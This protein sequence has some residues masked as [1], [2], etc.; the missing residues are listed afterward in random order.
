MESLIRNVRTPGWYPPA[1]ASTEAALLFNDVLRFDVNNAELAAA[2]NDRLRPAGVH[3][4]FTS[5]GVQLDKHKRR[6]TIAA[7]FVFCKDATRVW[8]Q[9]REYED[10]SVRVLLMGTH[11]RAGTQSSVWQWSEHELFDRNLV[12]LIAAFTRQ[13]PL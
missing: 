2:L 1:Y 7:F 5:R 4:I 11:K 8:Q 6:D 10:T 3:Y 9:V 13:P 12:R